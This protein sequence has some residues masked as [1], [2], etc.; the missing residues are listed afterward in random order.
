V[1][2]PALNSR[3]SREKIVCILHPVCAG[4][5][6]VRD[7]ADGV[8]V[9]KTKYEGEELMRKFLGLC[10]ALAFAL[11]IGLSNGASAKVGDKC[12][13]FAGPWCG[14]NEFC[15]KPNGAC[16]KPDISGKCA[17]K[18]EVCHLRKG[19]FYIKAC[20]CDGVTY[21][22]NCERMKAGVSLKHPGKC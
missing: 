16:F 17:A 10:A 21:A 19:V 7:R 4:A 8:V 6:A 1:A 9:R 18:P 11:V 12:G 22:N 13:G 14:P 3:T 15:Q 5:I 20:G 2:S